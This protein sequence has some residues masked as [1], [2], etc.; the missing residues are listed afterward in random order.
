MSEHAVPPGVSH[1]SRRASTSRAAAVRRRRREALAA[2]RASTVRD[3]DT[4]PQVAVAQVTGPLQP[5]TVPGGEPMRWLSLSLTAL[6]ALAG[7][8]LAALAIGLV[9]F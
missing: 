2:R 1:R 9:G 6:L 7:A 8:A 5:V 4:A 3:T